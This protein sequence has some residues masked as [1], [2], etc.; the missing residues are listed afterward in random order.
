MSLEHSAGFLS[1]LFFGSAR[2][3]GLSEK[4]QPSFAAVPHLAPAASAA[5]SRQEDVPVLDEDP[6]VQADTAKRTVQS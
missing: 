3:L 1:G 4:S 5:L 2:W 6:V